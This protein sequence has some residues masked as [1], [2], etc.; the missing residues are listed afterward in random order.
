SSMP[1]AARTAGS[2]PS[3][4][5]RMPASASS[6]RPRENRLRR[7]TTRTSRSRNTENQNRRT[8]SGLSIRWTC[9]R[10][11]CE[12]RCRTRSPA[13]E[14]LGEMAGDYM[15]FPYVPQRRLGRGVGADGG[16]ALVLVERAARGET[17][18]ADRLLE[19]K[20]APGAARGR[21][22]AAGVQI[23]LGAAFVRK[24]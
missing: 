6:A 18:T 5:S 14:G 10:L 16:A 3:W 7:A 19:V 21:R 15:P 17:A 13:S 20:H 24:R 8:R 4:G 22:A 1:Q 11:P 12:E 2:M 9:C 23:H